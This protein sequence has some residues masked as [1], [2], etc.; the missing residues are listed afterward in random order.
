MSKPLL[1]L[2]LPILFV[3]TTAAQSPKSQPAQTG[4]SEAVAGAP[5]DTS[6]EALIASIKRGDL[7]LVARLLEEGANPDA[8]DDVGSPALC[9]AV[10]VN[11]SDLVE[12]LIAQKAKIDKEES[13][14][15]TALHTAAAVGRK[16]LVKLL[17]AHGADVNHKD[18]GGHTALIVS[19]FGAMFKSAPEWLARSLLEIDENDQFFEMM[20]TEHNAV[21]E[22]LLNAGANVNAQGDD[23]GLTTL[24]I[25]AISGNAELAKI[26]LS[27]QADAN[28]KGGEWNALK[29]AE[30]FDSPES[31]E[32]EM[33]GVAD[34]ESK[35][36]LLNWIHFTAPGR[37]EVA[38]LLRTAGA[39]N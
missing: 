4:L 8:T 28:I 6:D 12:A 20:G 13:D 26:L 1:T 34:R 3:I 24:M 10:R 11:R 25:A 38:R 29:F 18:K 7:P 39:R 16:E 17:L 33:K 23:C 5:L 2:F 19:A 27:K 32:T 9:W 35:Q 21:V 31:I 14:G 22:L 36:A 15:G 30:Q 37:Q